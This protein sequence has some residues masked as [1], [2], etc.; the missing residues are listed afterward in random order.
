MIGTRILQEYK[1]ISIKELHEQNGYPIADLCNLANIARSS[2]YKWI[3][4]SETELDRKN[5]IILKEIVKLY[6]DVNGIYGYRR[7]TMNINRLL[8][9]QYNHKRIY[10][11][12]KSINMRSVIRKKRKSYIQSTP[13]I[14]AENKL[15]REFYANKPNEKWLTDVTEFKLLN[16]KKAYLS[17]IFDLADKSIVSYVVGHSNNNQLVFDTFDLAVSSN[18]T[19]KPLFHSDRGFQV[20]QEVA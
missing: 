14:T 11:L 18:P 6:E 19:A 2:Y 10:R 1:Y 7:I 4:R 20:R 13:Q 16:G 17:A 8:N 15:N 5:S 12:M 3:N 9:K